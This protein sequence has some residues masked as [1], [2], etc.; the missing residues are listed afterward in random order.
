[1]ER[2]TCCHLA[3]TRANLAPSTLVAP[4]RLRIPWSIAFPS[5]GKKRKKKK[6][7]SKSINLITKLV[8]RVS[9]SKPINPK[10]ESQ[11]LPLKPSKFATWGAFAPFFQKGCS[12]S[13]RVL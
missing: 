3:A 7:L 2:R 12:A 1:V 13:K 6:H 11:F 9:F 10:H 5:E 8:R 4:L